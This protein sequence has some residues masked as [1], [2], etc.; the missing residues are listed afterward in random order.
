MATAQVFPPTEPSPQV[1]GGAP[2]PHSHGFPAVHVESEKFVGS[3]TLVSEKAEPVSQAPKRSAHRERESATRSDSVVAIAPGSAASARV[4]QGVARPRSART[5]GTRSG[6]SSLPTGGSKPQTA[7]KT[8]P[9]PNSQSKENVLL[10]VAALL[11][12]GRPASDPQLVD[13][14]AVE[15]ASFYP[16]PSVLYDCPSTDAAVPSET[17]ERADEMGKNSWQTEP[18]MNGMQTTAMGVHSQVPASTQ[19]PMPG[20]PPQSMSML[21]SCG[22]A[23]T[24]P[25]LCI[26]ANPAGRSTQFLHGD[27]PAQSTM[28]SDSTCFH[29]PHCSA[30]ISAADIARSTAAQQHMRFQAAQ[31]PPLQMP[32]M[33]PLQPEMVVGHPFAT[34]P[35]LAP[36][37]PATLGATAPMP[38]HQMSAPPDVLQPVMPDGTF[39]APSSAPDAT[40]EGKKVSKPRP[41]HIIHVGS[42]LKD[43]VTRLTAMLPTSGQVAEILQPLLDN[44]YKS[45]F[46]YV[47]ASFLTAWMDCPVRCCVSTPC[48][49]LCHL[50]VSATFLLFKVHLSVMNSSTH[51][52]LWRHC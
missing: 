40:R 45:S 6:S 10:S 23:P 20:M 9:S 2:Q 28:A 21:S 27:F 39:S 52:M 13:A 51:H 36:Y 46:E 35:V 18:G 8:D 15:D 43:A 41:R 32:P 25:Q 3:G 38:A 22:L 37:P 44:A 30:A 5:A 24:P 47:S 7:Q 12:E 14:T 11:E 34:N 49:R 4:A 19:Q 48:V 17:L 1:S 29:C 33:P 50:R 26:P 31:R 42:E 16:A